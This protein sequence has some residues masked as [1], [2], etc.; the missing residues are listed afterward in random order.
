MTTFFTCTN[1][2]SPLETVQ[3]WE[4]ASTEPEVGAEDGNGDSKIAT[5]VDSGDIGNDDKDDVNR[6]HL[7]IKSG[8]EFI[9][10]RIYD[11]DTL[12]RSHEL[13]ESK[14]SELIRKQEGL[15]QTLDK[16]SSKSR[17]NN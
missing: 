10:P 13:R 8:T 5:T 2:I 14:I 1:H 4:K 12:Q 9:T 16:M 6:S 7:S 11:D 3:K 15:L 17:P